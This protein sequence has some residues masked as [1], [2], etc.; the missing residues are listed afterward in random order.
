MSHAANKKEGLREK[1]VARRSAMAEAER[2]VKSDAISRVVT[3]TNQFLESSIIAMYSPI[4]EEVTTRNIFRSARRM[5][6]TTAYPLVD[7]DRNML[8]FFIVN[9]PDR[10]IPGTYGIREPDM[11]NASEIA[12][13]ELDFILIPAVVLDMDGFRIGYGGGYYDRLLSDP[14]VQA[15]ST[16]IVYDFQVVE[17]LPRHDHDMPVDCITTESRIIAA[18]HT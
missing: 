7:K 10:L 13:H 16:A 18:A 6:K 1:Y 8:R 15:F 12:A 3:A 11:H 4:R 17:R 2:L 14:S 9:D 5:E